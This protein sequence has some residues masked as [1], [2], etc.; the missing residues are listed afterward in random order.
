MSKLKEGIHYKSYRHSRMI[1][2]CYGELYANKLDKYLSELNKFLEKK[3]HF[4]N[5]DARYI[6]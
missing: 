1:R 4:T 3:M 5:T 2:E 6:E